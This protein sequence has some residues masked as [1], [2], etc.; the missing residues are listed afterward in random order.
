MSSTSNIALHVSTKQVF[1]LAQQLPA[2]DKAELIHL[3]EQEQ[4]ANNIPEEHKKIVRSRIK[5]YN[6]NP[7]LL[8]DEQ[9]ALKM[10][11]AM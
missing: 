6:K 3:L 7:G 11:N 10:I 2:K 1:A 8:I 5:K 9:Q 4:Y